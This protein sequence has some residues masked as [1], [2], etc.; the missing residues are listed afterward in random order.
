M[1]KMKSELIDGEIIDTYKLHI[2]HQSY[3]SDCSE[4][5][6]E[7]R[8]MAAYR[9]INRELLA[10]DFS[11]ENVTKMVGNINKNLYGID[12]YENNN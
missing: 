12:P 11:F 9:L 10:N 2:Y 3:H 5:Y 8:L 1:A 6:K 4:C 7:D